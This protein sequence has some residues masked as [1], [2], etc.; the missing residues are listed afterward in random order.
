MSIADQFWE[1]LHPMGQG[2]E[3]S[4]TRPGLTLAVVT[5]VTDEEKLNR[6]KCLPIENENA[7]ETDW[8]Y[9]MTPMGGKSC[10][11]FFFPNVNDLVV[12]AYLGGDPHRPMVLG[13][14]WNTETP[15]PY[16]IEDGKVQNYSI[17]T[18]NGT[19]LLLYDE[20]DKQKVTLTLPSGAVLSIDDENKKID[21]KDKGGDNALS[22]DLNGGNL[23]LKAKSKI[24]LEVGSN[25]VELDSSG[26][27]TIKT[28]NKVAIQATN[29]EVKGSAKV[30]IQGAQTEV[31]ADATLTL[32]AS[33]PTAVKGAIV[34][35]N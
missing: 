20:K 29:I 9:V 25:K 19:E 6:V 7:E 5:N 31:K 8:C 11:Q 24:S 4:M 26:N 17:K 1:T 32:Q 30:A 34:N 18:P 10:G 28:S 22:M 27:L 15:A 3:E 12:L 16:T 14:F 2:L 13:S 35:I 21:L 33:G 23:S